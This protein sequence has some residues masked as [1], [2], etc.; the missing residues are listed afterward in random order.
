MAAC[1]ILQFDIGI[2]STVLSLKQFVEVSYGLEVRQ[3][4]HAALCTVDASAFFNSTV[5]SS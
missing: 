2:H 4:H 5:A 1:K 3:L